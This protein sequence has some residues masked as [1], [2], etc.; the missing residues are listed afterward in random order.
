L[1]IFVSHSSF[2]WF[3]SIAHAVADTIS[4]NDPN[5]YLHVTVKRSVADRIVSQLQKGGRSKFQSVSSQVNS[6]SPEIQ[7]SG[8]QAQF[9]LGTSDQTESSD[10]TYG[11]KTRDVSVLFPRLSSQPAHNRYPAMRGEWDRSLRRRRR[12]RTRAD[13][14]G[15]FRHC[16]AHLFLA[17]ELQE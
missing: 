1:T 9:S 12:C 11:W 5:P 8:S 4:P 14:T 6:H 10:L 7:S 16:P 3:V 13:P 15:Q 17:K 2:R